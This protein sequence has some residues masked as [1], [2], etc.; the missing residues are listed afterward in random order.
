MFV[1]SRVTFKCQSMFIHGFI[2]GQITQ[3]ITELSYTVP[4]T[5]SYVKPESFLVRVVN[6]FHRYYTVRTLTFLIPTEWFSSD[7]AHPSW[8]PTTVGSPVYRTQLVC[9]HLPFF[10]FVRGN[11]ITFSFSI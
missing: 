2:S 8:I 10:R 1:C 4:C 3:F 6:I 11:S 7:P 5:L 9:A